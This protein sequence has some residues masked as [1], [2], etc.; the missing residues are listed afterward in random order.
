MPRVPLSHAANIHQ[1]VD[2]GHATAPRQSVSEALKCGLSAVRVKRL[3][4]IASTVFA[5]LL[6]ELICLLHRC[7]PGHTGVGAWTGNVR[8]DPSKALIGV[9]HHDRAVLRAFYCTLLQRAPL[10]RTAG[11][12]CS[13]GPDQRRRLGVRDCAPSIVPSP[14]GPRRRGGARTALRSGCPR[15]WRTPLH[16]LPA[17]GVHARRATALGG[18]TSC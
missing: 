7:G 2:A 8:N 4:S 10:R 17:N 1:R 18:C 13:C 5:F 12:L 14:S 6:C 11:S 3:A 16:S 15:N 9:G